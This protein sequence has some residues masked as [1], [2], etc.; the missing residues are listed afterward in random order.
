MVLV[1]IESNLHLIE[2]YPSTLETSNSIP[3]ARCRHINFT[4]V[5]LKLK[6]G[7]EGNCTVLLTTQWGKQKRRNREIKQKIKEKQRS[8]TFQKSVVF[9]KWPLVLG[10]RRREIQKVSGECQE[11]N[12]DLEN[13]FRSWRSGRRKN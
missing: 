9:E 2:A 12:E 3:G 13:W 4:P 6:I 8:W 7:L 10:I 1:K 5:R 11:K